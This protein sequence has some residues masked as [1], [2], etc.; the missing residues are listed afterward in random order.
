MVNA[1]RTHRTSTKHFLCS[2]QLSLRFGCRSV[3]SPAV[4][5]YP[6]SSGEALLAAPYACLAPLCSGGLT[7]DCSDVLLLTYKTPGFRDWRAE[8]S[9]HPCLVSKGCFTIAAS[10]CVSDFT[11]S[12]IPLKMH[13]GRA[14]CMCVSELEGRRGGWVG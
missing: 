7:G 9:D 5:F 13:M 12:R 4:A 1:H 2:P 10:S 6:L 3:E 14:E 11:A 8:A